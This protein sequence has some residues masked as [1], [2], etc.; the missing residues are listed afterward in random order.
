[1]SGRLPQFLCAAASAFAIRSGATP[2]D[3]VHPDIAS[4]L[5]RLKLSGV[6]ASINVSLFKLFSV[7]K[8][9]LRRLLSCVNSQLLN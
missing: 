6:A 4:D 1:M 5:A 9:T 7:S 2:S 8:L 3:M